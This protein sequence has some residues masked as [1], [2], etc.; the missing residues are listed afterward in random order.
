[1]TEKEKMNISPWI[2]KA[3]GNLTPE[4]KEEVR[5]ILD[6]QEG[7]G[8]QNTSA[9]VD[10]AVAGTE[11]EAAQDGQL[12]ALSAQLSQLLGAMGSITDRLSALENA[13]PADS[14]EEAEDESQSDEADE[15]ANELVSA[16]SI[17]PFQAQSVAGA[18]RTLTGLVAAAQEAG[19]LDSVMVVAGDGTK[20]NVLEIFK[21]AMSQKP[22]SASDA[23]ADDNGD[24]LG[25]ANLYTIPFAQLK[26]ATVTQARQK[27]V[28]H[29]EGALRVMKDDE[30]KD[31]I[32]KAFPKKVG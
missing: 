15:Y 9:D 29:S 10:T 2:K 11:V 25:N 18:C 5:S 6:Q 28:E 22:A 21:A 1:M 30:I 24:I 27:T 23:S 8:E 4:A 7:E 26:G 13:N 12:G 17:L 32:D 14:T 31:V 19:Q 20:K 3:M 16:G